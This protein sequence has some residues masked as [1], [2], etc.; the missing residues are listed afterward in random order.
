MTSFAH[1]N[2]MFELQMSNLRLFESF[3]TARRNLA[4][5][6]VNAMNVSN[7][8]PGTANSLVDT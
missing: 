5:S 1:N 6:S 2:E 4:S 7:N 8:E 3:L